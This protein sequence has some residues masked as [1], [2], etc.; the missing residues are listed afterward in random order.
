[1]RYKVTF[2]YDGSNYAG[3]QSQINALAIQDIIEK[4][5]FNIYQKTIKITLASRT[6]AG[7]HALAQVFSYETDIEILE[8][9]IKEGI[10]AFMPKDI[11]IIEVKKV[12]DS[13]HPR[14]DVKE[15]TYEY[16]INIGEYNPLLVNR[17]Y[18]CKYK[19]DLELLEKTMKIFEGEHDFGSFNTSSYK[20]YPNQVRII[21]S[22]KMIKKGDLIRIRIV[23]TG[24]LRNMV[25]I[26][27][28][29]LIDVARGKVDPQDIKYML[30]NPSKGT[31]RYNI[32]PSGLY[33]INIKY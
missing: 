31:R 17:A 21:K 4:A 29:S 19:L 15:K 12:K 2:S 5:L 11:H 7:V 23:G 30:D 13:F 16:L 8:R 14:Y 27:V 20:E 33:L 28:G 10:N 32:S 25:R 24:F 9:K 26:I 3:L 6:D 1:M 22:I 18:Q